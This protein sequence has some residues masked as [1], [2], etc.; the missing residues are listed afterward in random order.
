ME[1][2][3]ATAAASSISVARVFS[4]MARAGRTLQVTP[5]TSATP[6]ITASAIVAVRFHIESKSTTTFGCT[7]WFAQFW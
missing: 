3:S 5:S 6:S 4:V 2:P 1:E 7:R